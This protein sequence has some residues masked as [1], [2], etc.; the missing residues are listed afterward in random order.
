MIYITGTL[1]FIFNVLNI[2]FLFLFFRKYNEYKQVLMTELYI[3]NE[4]QDNSFI[5]LGEF[6]ESRK[7]FLDSLNQ[8]EHKE[9]INRYNNAFSG[10]SFFSNKDREKLILDIDNLFLNKEKGE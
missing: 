1:I 8:E 9:I 6:L 2:Y 10:K 3:K 5:L 7:P 4:H